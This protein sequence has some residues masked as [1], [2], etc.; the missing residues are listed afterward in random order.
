MDTSAPQKNWQRKRGRRREKL[1]GWSRNLPSTSVTDAYISA[2][3]G[4]PPSAG[5]VDDEL[6]AQLVEKYVG[7][8]GHWIVGARLDLERAELCLQGLV[9]CSVKLLDVQCNGH[10]VPGHQGVAKPSRIL[11]TPSRLPR[12]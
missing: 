8:A 7:D 2:L 3:T 4:A 11:E 6:W 10:G 12:P 9:C 1:C 5:H